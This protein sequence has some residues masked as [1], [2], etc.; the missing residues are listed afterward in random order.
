[1][2]TPPKRVAVTGTTSGVDLLAWA[3]HGTL[4]PA[5]MTDHTVQVK[6]DSPNQIDKVVVTSRSTQNLFAFGSANNWSHHF[7]LIP[8]KKGFFNRSHQR[9]KSIRITATGPEGNDDLIETEATFESPT[10]A[11]LSIK[12]VTYLIEIRK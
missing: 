4:K 12:D 8:D 5:S 2:P 1:M 6:N 9:T 11:G 10:Q 3:Q 7:G